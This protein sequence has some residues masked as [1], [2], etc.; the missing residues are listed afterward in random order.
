MQNKYHNFGI[1]TIYGANLNIIMCLIITLKD[2]PQYIIKRVPKEA[3]DLAKI[4][5]EI[6]KTYKNLNYCG[7]TLALW[8]EKLRSVVMSNRKEPDQ[9]IKNELIIKQNSK[10]AHCQEILTDTCELD[11]ITRVSDGGNNEIN[12]LQYLCKLRH[13]DKCENEELLNEIPDKKSGNLL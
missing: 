6:Q 5:N 12:K 3:N 7:E 10:C 8:A 4:T 11:H 1:E 2:H 13:N 9:I